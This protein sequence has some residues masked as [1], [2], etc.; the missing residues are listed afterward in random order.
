MSGPESG[1]SEKENMYSRRHDFSANVI[2]V[3]Y[4]SLCFSGPLTGFVPANVI[5]S[6]CHFKF[7]TN[8]YELENKQAI[9]TRDNPEQKKKKKLNK[10]FFFSPS[11]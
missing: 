6:N 8:F 7:Q 3:L 5:P 9:R 10:Y 1:R 2:I 11:Q 4:F